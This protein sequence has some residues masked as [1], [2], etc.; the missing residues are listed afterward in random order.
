MRLVPGHFFGRDTAS[1]LLLVPAPPFST[2][3]FLRQWFLVLIWKLLDV[4]ED[5]IAGPVVTSEVKEV[6]EEEE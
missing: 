3:P 4:V 5:T 1:S 2:W 6:R